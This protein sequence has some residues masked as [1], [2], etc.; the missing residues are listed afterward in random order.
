MS[1][2]RDVM[3][4]QELLDSQPELYAAAVNQGMQTERSR[5]L[6]HLRVAQLYNSL[7]EATESIRAGIPASLAV[8]KK[9][10][11]L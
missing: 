10:K 6:I 8:M 3:T 4:L 5:V 11:V 1:G 7:E 2:R 9:Q